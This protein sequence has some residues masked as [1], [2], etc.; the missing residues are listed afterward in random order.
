[1]NILT[2]VIAS[3]LIGGS[4]ADPINTACPISER[5]VDAS[6]PT[7]TIDGKTVAV[8]CNR[9]MGK[10]EAMDADG[11]AGVLATATPAP[12]AREI[13]LARAYLLPTCPLSGKGIDDMGK[14]ATKR[15]GDRDVMVCCPPCFKRVEG[16]R[17][18][19]DAKIDE[20]IIKRQRP[21]Y[22]LDTCI[23]SGR[24]LGEDRVDLVWGNRL[25]RLCCG[26]CVIAFKDQPAKHLKALDAA[27]ITAVPPTEGATC[28]VSGRPL[29][30]SP[31]VTVIGNRVIRT[32]CGNCLKKIEA[33]PR[34]W[35]AKADSATGETAPA[36]P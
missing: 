5:P 25:V 36:G 27:L 23:M 1:M 12:E 10:I 7:V 30:D 15:I 28:V 34:G 20:Q 26:R 11:K 19:Y 31:K 3:L 14:A 8:C 2:I 16:D 22:P 18:K 4:A 9:C 32:C 29:G 24:P 6:S 13:V 17:A 35:V 33:N 21:T